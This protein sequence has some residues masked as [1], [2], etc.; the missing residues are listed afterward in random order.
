MTKDDASLYLIVAGVWGD[1]SRWNEVPYKVELV[2]EGKRKVAPESGAFSSSSSTLALWEFA[3]SLFNGKHYGHER[4]KAVVKIY[5]LSSLA[6]KLLSSKCGSAN[7]FGRAVSEYGVETVRSYLQGYAKARMKSQEA[8]LD[9][10]VAPT[11]LTQVVD[12]KGA[13]LIASMRS[14]GGAFDVVKTA[15]LAG[16]TR[17]LLNAACNVGLDGKVVFIADTTH[18]INYTTI[19][20]HEAARLSARLAALLAPVLCEREPPPS[21][22]LMVYNSDPVLRPPLQPGGREAYKIHLVQTSTLEG[23]GL[24]HGQSLASMVID[25]SSCNSI[26]CLEDRLKEE[27]KTLPNTVRK[28]PLDLGAVRDLAY[29]LAALAGGVLPYSLCLAK[30]LEGR[31]LTVQSPIQLIEELTRLYN[32][33]TIDY[34]V[35]DDIVLFNIRVSAPKESWALTALYLLILLQRIASLC[36]VSVNGGSC[37][38]PLSCLN[39]YS[40]LLSEPAKA[41]LDYEVNELE[42]H[43]KELKS[44]DCREW[45]KAKGKLDLRVFQAHA[46]LPGGM[47]RVCRGEP[48]QGEESGL[49]YVQI[50]LDKTVEGLLNEKL[51][52]LLKPVKTEHLRTR[53]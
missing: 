35:Q 21:I 7:D 12:C 27:L 22:E 33:Y 50:Q 3:R 51:N 23:R 30:R 32:E 16:L 31:I 18:G 38:I 10:E 26:R 34:K 48:V 8:S 19:A 28:D 20:F 6:L 49:L 13:K 5:G 47:T 2:W 25:D 53:S 17:D 4:V 40:Y 52:R 46:G 44:G 42:R 41:L 37:V 9:V 36:G 45:E 29:M 24:G 15:I 43:A 11:A 39:T 14:G 1:P